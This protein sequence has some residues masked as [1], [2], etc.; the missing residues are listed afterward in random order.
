MATATSNSDSLGRLT[1]RKADDVE[2]SGAPDVPSSA[3]W[4]LTPANCR[5]LRNS[6]VFLSNPLLLSASK[7]ESDK[8]ESSCDQLAMLT[9]G[10]VDVV[11]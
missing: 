3:L 6:H 7:R 5:D 1:K 9:D 10:C 11:L 4:A 2:I 8:V